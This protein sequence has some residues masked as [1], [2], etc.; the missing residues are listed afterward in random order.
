MRRHI[1]LLV[2]ACILAFTDIAIASCFA[3]KYENGS[4]ERVICSNLTNLNIAINYGGTLVDDMM[5]FQSQID[6]IPDQ[7]FLRYSKSLVSLNM[8][9]CGIREI[10]GYAF[11]GLKYMKKLGL[12]YN[13]ITSVKDQWFVG[14]IFLEQL[15]LSYN[16]IVS[17]ESTVFETLRGLKRLDVRKNRLTCLEPAQLAPMAGIERFHF[18]GNPF[19]FRCRGTL[20]LWLQ[21]LGINYKTEQRGDEDWLDS[22]LWLCAADDGKVADSE[23]LM[24]ECVILNLF[25]QLRTGLT[26]AES[27]PLSIPQECIYARNELTKCVTTDRRRGREVITNGHVMRKLLRQLMESKS[28]V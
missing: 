28:T 8:R 26:T 19:T 18:S 15:D 2:L 25:N 10:S 13:N 14:L 27:F 16:N 5:I 1:L 11:D 3:N 20:T 6:N 4:H 23:V 22:I 21:D 17:I 9:D 12:S 7:S 24:K